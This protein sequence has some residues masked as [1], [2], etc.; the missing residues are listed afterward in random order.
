MASSALVRGERG[1]GGIW[2]AAATHV[3]S[4]EQPTDPPADREEGLGT[5]DE[6]REKGVFN[7]GSPT[8]S[9]LSLLCFIKL[10]PL[11][12]FLNYFIIN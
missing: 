7:W 11:G 12:F 8:F 5:W 1:L 3:Q 4:S 2:G 6:E 10:I 9:E